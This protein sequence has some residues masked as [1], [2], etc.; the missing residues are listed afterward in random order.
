MRTATF[1]IALVVNFILLVIAIDL[2]KMLFKRQ[3]IDKPTRNSLILLSVVVPIFGFLMVYW[4][5]RSYLRF[6]KPR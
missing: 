3:V 2:L 4:R 5:F 1:Y 6:S